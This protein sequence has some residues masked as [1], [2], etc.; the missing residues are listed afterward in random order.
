M[1]PKL[2]VHILTCSTEHFKVNMQFCFV[3][4]FV[5]FRLHAAVCHKENPKKQNKTKIKK[6]M[7][8]WLDF[9]VIPGFQISED[10]AQQLCEI[11]S[12][13]L[14]LLLQLINFEEGFIRWVWL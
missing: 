1:L 2:Q 14:Q 8:Q 5:C 12:Q 11:Y 3:C 13:R 7:I 9:Q 4:L 10:I 6:I